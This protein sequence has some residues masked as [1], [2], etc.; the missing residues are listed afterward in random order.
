MQNLNLISHEFG[1]RIGV[2]PQFSL[3]PDP[4]LKYIPCNR[5]VIE[6]FAEIIDGFDSRLDDAEDF[7][8]GLFM[9]ELL[10]TLR[11]LLEVELKKF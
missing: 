7:I 10:E 4:A 8:H 3:L 9:L 2:N 6:K 1:C 5:V 11:D